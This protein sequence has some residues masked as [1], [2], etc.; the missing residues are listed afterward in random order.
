[1]A[2]ALDF[3]SGFWWEVLSSLCSVSE[4]SAFAQEVNE[5]E[6]EAE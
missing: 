6:G 4:T 5:E 2:D 3:F 1:L